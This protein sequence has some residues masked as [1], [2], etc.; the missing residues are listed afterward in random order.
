MKL[1]VNINVG[2]KP[3]HIVEVIKGMNIR[4][5]FL[6]IRKRGKEKVHLVM[7]INVDGGDPE[8][9]FIF[10]SDEENFVYACSQEKVAGAITELNW[11]YE[12]EYRIID[13]KDVTLVIKEDSKEG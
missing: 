3:R 4:N 12:D 6:T 13:K 9:N 11:L 1:S 2:G 5:Q 8:Q 10:I 7:G